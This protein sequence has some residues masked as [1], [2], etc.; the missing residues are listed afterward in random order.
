M[1]KSDRVNK[2]VDPTE[3]SHEGGS[4][5]LKVDIGNFV[6]GKS[7]PCSIFVRIGKRKFLKLA[8]SYEEMPRETLDR[9]RQNH[10][11]HLYVARDEYCDLIDFNLD[12]ASAINKK[13]TKLAPE[14]VRNFIK[15][16][17]EV[18]LEGIFIEGLN[19]RIL[20]SAKEYTK[21]V[22]EVIRDED[23]IIHLLTSLADHSDSLYAHS[24]EVAMLSWLVGRKLG[25]H[26][27][28]VLFKVF[29][30]GL[31]HDIGLKEV[32][33]SL[34]QKKRAL[35]T[36]EEVNLYESHA[37]KG[38]EILNSCERVPE[39]AILAAY[40]HHEDCVGKGFPQRLKKHQTSP[41]ARLIRV[42]DLY[43][44]QFGSDGSIGDYQDIRKKI[45]DIESK[46]ARSYDG[47]FWK[48][49]KET[50]HAQ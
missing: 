46:S 19:Q 35:W 16:T 34:L 31:L 15:Y 25:W 10:K 37:K 6:T 43:C 30:A 2:E 21:L 40:H 48:G 7:L 28:P 49:L 42:V 45:K 47:K 14:K 24:L 23:D 33:K 12:I 3:L 20:R 29:L 50:V 36:Y 13:R 9:F 17:G 26:S 8:N 39:E 38:M 4:D 32:D 18:V 11:R 27:E 22:F 44:T 41:I 5:Y 1:A